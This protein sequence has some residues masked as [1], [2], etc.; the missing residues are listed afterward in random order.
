[1]NSK[2]RYTNLVKGRYWRF[3][4]RLVGNVALPGNPGEPEF[5]RAYAALLEQTKKP[6]QTASVAETSLKR[7]II[8]FQHSPEFKQLKPN[9]QRDYLRVMA[10]LE[11][12]AGHINYRTVT[13]AG[14]IALRNRF[15]ETPRKANYIVQVLSL[16]LSWAVDQGKL[17]EN[18]VLGTKKLRL[19]GGGYKPWPEPVIAKFLAE[20]R[21]DI[22]LGVMLG[23][24]TGQRIGDVVEMTKGRYLGG[25]IEVRQNKTRELL[26]IVCAKPLRQWLDRRPFP[27]APTLLVRMDGTPYPSPGSFSNVLK[28]EIRRLE[29]DD[30]L[31][32]HGLRYAAAARLEAAGASLGVIQAITGHRT[33]QMATQYATKRR[34]SEEAA[35][36]LSKSKVKTRSKKVK[37]RPTE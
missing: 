11:E 24:Y 10:T 6:Q 15:Q 37:T 25:E 3:R 36:L 7:L 8:D 26:P 9:T 23:L 28:A 21:P 19:T 31:S 2:P 18:K 30:T 22:A 4:H 1:M 17:D 35:R 13:R 29:L 33:Y 5:H 14:A 34:G 16:L 12:L 20:A 27:E 32:F